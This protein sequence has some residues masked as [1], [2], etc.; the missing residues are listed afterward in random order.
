MTINVL[1]TDT[2]ADVCKELERI[3][4]QQNDMQVIGIANDAF[5]ARK[6]IKTL[7]PDVLTL[8]I[9]F[10]RMNGLHFLD[11]LMSLR[12]MPV[13]I[14]SK[15]AEEK[16]LIT[17]QA[18]K[19]GATAC[20][21]K[22]QIEHFDYIALEVVKQIREATQ[23]Y[24]KRV[25]NQLHEN[26]KEKL[27]QGKYLIAIGASTG[28][29]EAITKILTEMPASCPGIVIAQ[30]MPKGFT[31]SFATRLTGLCNIDVCEAKH[32]QLIRPGHAYI[33]PGD[34]HL[35]VQKRA[36]CYYTILCDKDPVN[37]HKPSIDVLFTSVADNIKTC[38]IGIILT[39]M[40]KDGAQGL[41]KMHHSGA[42][43]FAQN[44]ASCVVYGMPKEA[45]R[46]GAVK[47]QLPLENIANAILNYVKG[48]SPQKK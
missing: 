47:H 20:I 36:G 46:I 6:M 29:T 24:E 39:G 7:Q 11:K 33:A 28:G 21:Y 4:S 22:P 17:E 1:I 3:I 26:K 40:G 18:L 32:N 34:F 10:P 16:S 44:E 42:E 31:A 38:A 2:S 43:T 19:I 25:L 8:S 41:L 9:E 45:K 13:V 15:L 35:L 14:I 23:I 12:P 48:P 27:D 5:Q 37:L 30:H